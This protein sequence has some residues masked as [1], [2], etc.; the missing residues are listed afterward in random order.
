MKTVKPILFSAPMVRAIL[1]KRKTQTRRIIDMSPVDRTI[2]TVEKITYGEVVPGHWSAF[3]ENGHGVGVKHRYGQTGGALWV[4]ETFTKHLNDY[5]Y[6]A[7]CKWHLPPKWKP[8]I[9]MPR[10]ANRIT[11]EIKDIR[12]E[13]VRDIS[14]EDATAEGVFT[15]EQ[16]PEE[17]D[18]RKNSI[19]CTKCA[20]TGLHND[21]GPNLGVIFDV[22]CNQCETDKQKFKNLWGAINGFERWDENPWVWV[23][24]FEAHQ[25]N[26]DEYL[27]QEREKNEQY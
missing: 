17:H 8:S 18:Y 27:K 26:I 14:E 11:L 12:V 10:I 2:K 25:C 22:D 3:N 7:T 9:H 13:R 21:V 6:A 1:E 4:R 5:E 16:R 23:V 20:G 15:D 19:L 24:E